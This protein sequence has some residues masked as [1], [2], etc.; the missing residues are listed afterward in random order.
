MVFLALVIG[1]SAA[2]G[3]VGITLGATDLSG[4][5]VVSGARIILTV[6]G[7]GVLTVATLIG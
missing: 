6:F 1:F 5:R 3:V 2:F 4:G 7:R